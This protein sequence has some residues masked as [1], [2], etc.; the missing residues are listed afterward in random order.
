MMTNMSSRRRNM[1]MISLFLGVLMCLGSTRTSEAFTPA[2]LRPIT[3]QH[4]KEGPSVALSSAFEPMEGL[5]SFGSTLST[6]VASEEVANAV[7]SGTDPLLLGG[8]AVVALALVAFVA[9]SV[10]KDK[11]SE[12]PTPPEPEPEPIDVSIPYDA[13]IVLAYRKA[14]GKD[15]EMEGECYQQF[16]KLYL[17]QA[18]MEVSF[19]QKT[20]AMESFVAT[21][22]V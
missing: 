1:P 16:K 5:C 7:T 4:V 20:K 22:E 8:G 18:V 21:I 10:N 19:K 6:A 14:L 13:T 9:S 12:P 15:P 17:E 11:V 2:T 3:T